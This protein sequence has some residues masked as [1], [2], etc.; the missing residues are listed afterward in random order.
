MGGVATDKGNGTG[1]RLCVVG[2]GRWGQNHVRTLHGMGAL[3]G[4]CDSDAARLAGLVAQYGCAGFATLDEALAAGCDGFV[5]AT[6]APTHAAIAARIL[7]AGKP[8]LVEKPMTLASADAE[9]LVALA[10]S[11]G[12]ALMVG[13]LLLFHPAIRAIKEA[14]DAG[15]IGRVRSVESSRLNFGTV[16]TEENVFWSFAPHDLAIVA[17]IVGAPFERATATGVRALGQGREDAVTAHLAY[18]GGV[19]GTVRVSWLHPTKE[20]KL[21]VVGDRG[22][23][24]FDDASA[25]KAVRLYPKRFDFVDGQPVKAEA[26]EETIPYEPSAPL[27]NELRYFLEHLGGGGTIAD[28]RNGLEVVRALEQVDRALAAGRGTAG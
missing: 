11:K 16:R 6:P 1:G 19:A 15:R 25:D 21:V 9:A 7:E 14:V 17:E 8:V 26:P 4:V 5:V 18:P 23:L 24:T 12:V 3:G 27:E 28:G 13:H 20:Q 2:G 10:A 22:M